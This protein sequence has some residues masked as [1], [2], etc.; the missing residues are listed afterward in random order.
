MLL[1]PSHY[2]LSDSA[3]SEEYEASKIPVEA[4]KTYTGLSFT[5]LCGYYIPTKEYKNI[6]KEFSNR[7]KILPLY[8]GVPKFSDIYRLKFYLDL[9]FYVKSHRL[10]EKADIVHH[11]LPFGYK[12]T[13]NIV[14]KLAKKS[15]RPFI[16]GPLQSPQFFVGLDEH[17]GIKFTKNKPL[18]LL[19]V[20]VVKMISSPVLFKLFLDTLKSATTLIAVTNFAKRLYMQFVDED[21]IIV[22][23]FGI[24]FKEI[25]AKDYSRQHDRIS[26]MYAGPLILR[27]GIHYLLLALAKISKRYK[28]VELHI[29]GDGPQLSYLKEL[30]Q[31]LRI[32]NKVYFHGFMPRRKLLMEYAKHDIYVHPSISESFGIAI[33]EA[34][35]AGLPVVAF[36]IPNVNEI[37]LHK[38]TGLLVQPSN[39]NELTDSLTLLIEDEKLRKKMGLMAR[40]LVSEIYDWKVISSKYVKVYEEALNRA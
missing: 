5:I 16:I 13:F 30:A 40:R 10:V 12:T 31:T 34:M 36:N 22:I 29:Y 28:D 25:K 7:I 19:R 24:D 6:V 38:K 9:Y 15:G 20:D 11:V 21:K 39:V 37:V 4:V 27:K 14:H 33:L 26:L 18:E 1:A 3:G 2:I 8:G 17:V 32:K 23:P 35:A